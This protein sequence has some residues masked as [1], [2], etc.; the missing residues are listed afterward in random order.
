MTTTADSATITAQDRSQGR[1][2][3]VHAM[4]EAAN[5]EGPKRSLPRRPGI[6]ADSSGLTDR[7]R[8]VIEVIR[9]SAQRRGYPPSMREIGQAVGLSPIPSIRHSAATLPAS[10]AAPAAPA[11][12]GASA[13]GCRPT[14]HTHQA[15][16]G[17]LASSAVL[18]CTPPPHPLF[19]YAGRQDEE[20]QD[21]RRDTR[22]GLVKGSDLHGSRGPV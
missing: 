9:D 10:C 3:P 12:S 8:R 17:P 4:N 18:F 14:R 2:E 20:R 6:R 5:H 16:P 7:Q 21:G 1:L 22:L 19:P 11:V 13:E 15:T